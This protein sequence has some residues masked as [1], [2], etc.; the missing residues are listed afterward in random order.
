VE[1][2]NFQKGELDPFDVSRNS[3]VCLISSALLL[4][5]QMHLAQFLRQLTRLAEEF[6]VAVLITNQVRKNEF[7]FL[8]LFLLSRRW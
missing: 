8:F 3:S 1:E 4:H 7:F 2:Q 5:R 6:G